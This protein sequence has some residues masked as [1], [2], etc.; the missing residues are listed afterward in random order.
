MPPSTPSSGRWLDLDAVEVLDPADAAAHH[1]EQPLRLLPLAAGPVRAAEYADA[2]GQRVGGAELLVELHQAL[3]DGGQP[4]VFALHLV[5]PAA[6]LAGQYVDTA[7]DADDGL[8]GGGGAVELLLHADERRPEHLA[9]LG[10]QVGADL[11]ALVDGGQ[12]VVDGVTGPQPL[13]RLGQLL[14]GELGDGRELPVELLLPGLRLL[15]DPR[16]VGLGLLG[17]LRVERG[18]F[19]GVLALQTGHV[20]LPLLGVFGLRVPEL[21]GAAAQLELGADEKSYGDGARSRRRDPGDDRGYLG[22]VGSG[23]RGGDGSSA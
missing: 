16:L 8:L 13:Q 7:A 12:D 20:L 6:Q 9:Q 17:Q 2:R 4:A 19:G 22:R 5:E 14:V 15:G 3:G 18:A 23:D 21:A 1:A 11:R 10:L